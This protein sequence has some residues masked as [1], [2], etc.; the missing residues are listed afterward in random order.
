MTM[1]RTMGFLAALASVVMIAACGGNGGGGGGGVVVLPGG[2]AYFFVRAASN[3]D[4]VTV[5]AGQVTHLHGTAYD[6][7]M[8]VLP[9]NG[10]T[11]W[12]SRSPSIATVDTHGTVST[13]GIGQ[14]WVLG[15]FTAKNS[16]TSFTDS[17]LV[18]VL[19]P[20]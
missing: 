8:N 9:L 13:I 1:R 18:V 19:G 4:T 2:I 12:T 7:N 14:V 6:G 15:T 10:D 16:S 11:V 20:S 5:V 17:A 3:L